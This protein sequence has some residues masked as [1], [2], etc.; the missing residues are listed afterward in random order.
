MKSRIAGI[1]IWGLLGILLFPSCTPQRAIPAQPPQYAEE[2]RRLQA[3]LQQHPDDFT[4]LRELGV[5]YYKSRKYQLAIAVLNK[6]LEL[7]PAD[8]RSASYLGLSYEFSSEFVLAKSSYESALGDSA[9]NAYRS[10]LTGR[11]NLL[12][13]R[14][15]RNELV[16]ML[17]QNGLRPG[18]APAS[19]PRKKVVVLPVKYLGNDHKL[20]VLGK[21]FTEMLIA[22]LSRIEALKVV[23]RTEIEMLMEEVQRRESL[24]QVQNTTSGIG[25]LLEAD[26]MIRCGY[27]VLDGQI[28]W[29]VALW[30]LSNEQFPSTSTIAG[31]LR[32]MLHLQKEIT[33]ELAE[34]L[35]IELRPAVRK[36]I[37]LQPTADFQAFL[38]F[39]AGLAKEDAG[40]Y[41]EALIYLQKARELDPAFSACAVKLDENTALALALKDPDK[42]AM[43]GGY[44]NHAE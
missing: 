39:C 38:A 34:A 31:E 7:R 25:R 5:L 9:Q 41:E 37:E 14:Q 28:I 12:H 2:I 29:D 24:R 27:N 15:L 23:E 11:V 22:D 20:A 19:S 44:A 43:G 32:D 17:K 4:A 35:E 18:S 8:P 42:V 36:L 33:F 1:M 6:A 26:I 10:W 21:G 30:D 3:Q 16:L 40:A 13:R